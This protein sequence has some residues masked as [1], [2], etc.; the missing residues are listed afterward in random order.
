VLDPAFAMHGVLATTFRGPVLVVNGP[1][2]R[3]IG[4]NAKGNAL[5]QGNRAT[6]RSGVRFS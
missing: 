6:R 4:M 3:Q 5:G 2:R 1:V